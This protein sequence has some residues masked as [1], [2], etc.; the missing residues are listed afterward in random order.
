M[1]SLFFAGVVASVVVSVARAD[2]APAA[3]DRYG[4]MHMKLEKTI[5]GIDAV[6]VDLWVD[7]ATR[8]RVRAL[9]S[10]QRYSEQL[11]EGIARTALEAQDVRVQVEFLRDVSLGEF[12]DAVRENLSDAR[13]AGY[14]SNDTFAS[15]WRAAQTDFARLEGHGFKRGDR[16]IYLARPDSLKTTVTSGNQ[17]LLDVTTPGPDARRAMI[18]SYFAPKSDFRKGL[19]KSVF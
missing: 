6:R 12:L 18:A 11:A 1:R 4:H 14:I 10:G 7:D 13:N 16:L 2:T 8:D 3:D 17:V 19:I 15:S 9:A 5:L